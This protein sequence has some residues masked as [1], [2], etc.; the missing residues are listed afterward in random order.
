[1]CSIQLKSLQ[2]FSFFFNSQVNIWPQSQS[3]DA[4]RCRR[5]TT[6]RSLD[7][8]LQ[9]TWLFI[10]MN[11]H[12]QKLILQ[13]VFWCIC[14]L[15]LVIINSTAGHFFSYFNAVKGIED[16]EQFFPPPFCTDADTEEEE[17]DFF[18]A[19]F[20]DICLTHCYTHLMMILTTLNQWSF[21]E[22]FC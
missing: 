10:C 7:G 14:S 17:L 2:T 22:C 16:P 11:I 21:S 8:S 1:M 18:S 15:T 9:S 3:S 13:H 12:R 5:F 20:W 6:R 19:F 4:S